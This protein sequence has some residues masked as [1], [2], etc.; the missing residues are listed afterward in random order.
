MRA[1]A[2][3]IQ[4]RPPLLLG[5]YV[6]TEGPEGG[7]GPLWCDTTTSDGGEAFLGNLTAIVKGL[8]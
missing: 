4:Q 8:N 6:Q 2:C 3:H 1:H 5:V 7:T